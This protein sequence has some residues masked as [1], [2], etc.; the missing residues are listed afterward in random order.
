MV[1]LLAVAKKLIKDKDFRNLSIFVIFVLVIGA[2]FY[3]EYEGWGWIDSI[4]FCVTTLTTVGLG[5]IYPQTDLG[6]IFTSIYLLIGIGILLGYIKVIADIVIKDKAGL[7]DII[8]EKTMNIKKRID[9]SKGAKQKNSN[10]T[11]NEEDS[12]KTKSKR[13]S[14]NVKK[15]SDH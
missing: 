5:D 7:L 14:K 6:K 13:R 9:G 11:Q 10:A 12:P 2:L 15:R 8:T 1:R 4:Y 3:H